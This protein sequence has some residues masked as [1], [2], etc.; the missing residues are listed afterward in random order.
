M[1]Y[2][3]LFPLLDFVSVVFLG[4]LHAHVSSVFRIIGPCQRVVLLF[5][6]YTEL[7]VYA[8]YATDTRG[9]KLLESQSI[10]WFCNFFHPAFQ[11]LDNYVVVLLDNLGHLWFMC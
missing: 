9:A 5:I 4:D 11:G 2:S 1:L 6:L 7:Y 3:I 8:K 10:K